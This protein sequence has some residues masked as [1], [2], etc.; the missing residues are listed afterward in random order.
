MGGEKLVPTPA[1]PAWVHAASLLFTG[2]AQFFRRIH[3]V[4]RTYQ[5]APPSLWE[6]GPGITGRLRATRYRSREDRQMERI[7]FF[8]AVPSAPPACWSTPSIGDAVSRDAVSRDAVSR[9]ADQ[10]D[11]S[12]SA[13]LLAM[14]GHDLRQPLQVITSAHDVLARTLAIEE[15]REELRRAERATKRLA[16]MVGQLVEALQLRERSGDDLHVSVP[17]RPIL[18]ELAAEFGEAARLKRLAFVVNSPGG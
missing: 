14:A 9:D 2:L 8:D 11:S 12:F 15:E 3:A 16:G 1:I 5:S 7:G 13:T 18:R 10:A 17:L 6:R 4:P